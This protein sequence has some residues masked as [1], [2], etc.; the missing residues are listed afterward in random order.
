M[1]SPQMS[2]SLP[3]LL[4]YFLPLCLLCY[5]QVGL[6]FV[7]HTWQAHADLY[8]TESFSPISLKPTII[9]SEKT[10]IQ[11]KVAPLKPPSGQ[12]LAHYLFLVTQ[13][14]LPS[15]EI[16][17]SIYLL[18]AD[19]QIYAPCQQDLVNLIILS[20]QSNWHRVG[21]QHKYLLAG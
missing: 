17:S 20:Q 15:S 18:L 16:I 9:F 7:S 1:T 6:L 21:A 13:Q 11:F 4:Y 12:S 3:A 5:S 14:R 10:S 8:V 2:W 19:F